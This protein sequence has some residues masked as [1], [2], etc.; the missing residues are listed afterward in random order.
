MSQIGVKG[1][2]EGLIIS[3]PLDGDNERVIETLHSHLRQS[4][5]FFK[6]AVVTLEVGARPLD[7]DELQQIIKILEQWEVRL[8]SVRASDDVTRSAA[9]SL[10]LKL[11]FV[12]DPEVAAERGQ[13]RIAVPRES[14]DA[15]LVRRTLRS[16]QVIRHPGSVIVLGDVNPGAE[17]V[18]GGDIVVWGT[19]R[20]VVHAGAMGDDR[21][22][23]CA[24]KL[25]PTQLRISDQIAV[26]PEEK[27]HNRIHLWKRR[28]QQRPELA[29]LQ[30]EEIVVESWP[31]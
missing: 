13:R 14:V 27:E 19:L 15:L 12:V 9:L 22:I 10:D 16:G 30:E 28:Y 21:A 6:G 8:E 18:A 25:S 23:V 1:D 3:L 17:I 20:G 31:K 2:R 24:L 26:A 5:A 11:P 7:T 4:G 29:R